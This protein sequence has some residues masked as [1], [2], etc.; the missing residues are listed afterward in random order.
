MGITIHYRGQLKSPE[1]IGQVCSKLEEMAKLMGWEYKLF[2]KNLNR[3]NTAKLDHSGNSPVITGQL[4]LKGIQLN[5][6]KDC[7]SFS[8]FFDKHGILHDIIQMATD[9]SEKDEKT[10]Y[11]HVKTQFA[12]LEVH[13]AIIRLLKY[14]HENF[15][16]F[17]EVIDEGEYWQTEDES[18]LQQKMNCLSEKIKTVSQAIDSAKDEYKY[19]DSDKAL[20]AKIEEILQE[21]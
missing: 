8:L 12:P 16:N 19:C 7:E 1:L 11:L 13:I 3:P 20:A 10:S 15:F 2:D 18:L 14:L 4:P 9:N 17:L 5:I 6:H 21:K